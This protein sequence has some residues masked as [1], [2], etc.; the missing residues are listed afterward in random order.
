MVKLYTAKPTPTRIIVAPGQKAVTVLK[1]HDATRLP[2]Q[3]VEV[4]ADFI[5]NAPI[6]GF[7]ERFKAAMRAKGWL[8]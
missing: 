7:S 1:P 6:S 5:G 8:R 3:A 4:E 2:F